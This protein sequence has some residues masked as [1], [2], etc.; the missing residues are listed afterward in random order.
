MAA[1]HHFEVMAVFDKYYKAAVPVF[2]S[3]LPFIR[4]GDTKDRAY[5]KI[6][7]GKWEGPAGPAGTWGSQ[8]EARQR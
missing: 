3:F 5:E 8:R 1:K 2:R 7:T 6:R 4:D